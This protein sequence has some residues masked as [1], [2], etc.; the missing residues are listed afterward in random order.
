M[1]NRKLEL[2]K[3]NIFTQ[4]MQNINGLKALIPFLREKD[5]AKLNS[6]PS[7]HAESTNLN[8]FLD[9]LNMEDYKFLVAVHEKIKLSGIGNLVLIRLPNQKVIQTFVKAWLDNDRYEAI[10]GNIYNYKNS[11]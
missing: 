10:D 4:T 11:I 8:N 6:M 5:I 7:Y 1:N 2:A 9:S 3:Q